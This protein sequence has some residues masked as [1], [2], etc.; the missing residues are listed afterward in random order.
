MSTR[1]QW[2]LQSLSVF[3]PPPATGIVAITWVDVSGMTTG[4]AETCV[5]RLPADERDR[6]LRYRHALSAH[7]FLAG[8]LLLRG[9]L[10]AVSGTPA[11][12]WR[13]VEGSRGRPAIAHPPSPWSFN[14]A[15]S[16]GVVACVLS[17][18]ADVGVDVEHLDRRPMERDLVKRFCSPTEIADIEAQPEDARLRRFLTHWT[19]KEA[20]LKA[21]GLGIAVHLADLEF[22]LAEPHPTI[23]FRK[24]LEGTDASWAFALFQPTPRCLLS[25][26]APQPAGTPRPVFDVHPVSLRTLIHA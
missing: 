19:L 11:S 13:F 5:S 4:Q 16:G 6:F 9:W 1:A 21:R 3:P 23:A 22:S 26:A 2:L 18:I 20:Y 17:Q 8:R 7:Q 15:H 10:E 14:L 12:A 25:A 24:S